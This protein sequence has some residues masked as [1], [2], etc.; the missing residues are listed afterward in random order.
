MAIQQEKNTIMKARSSR[1]APMLSGGTT[2]R[3]ALIGGSVIVS[4][5][6][7]ITNIAPVGRQSADS[8]IKMF[9]TI[10]PMRSTMKMNRANCNA[11][12]K[13]STQRA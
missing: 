11:E 6:S 3:S 9:T 4:I 13:S 1:T 7:T 2:L 8:D 10:L 5:A 12:T